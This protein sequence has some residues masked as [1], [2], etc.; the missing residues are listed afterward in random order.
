MS[1][2]TTKKEKFADLKRR[3][4]EQKSRSAVPHTELDSATME[5]IDSVDDP[6]LRLSIMDIRADRTQP[7]QA[8][9]S[10]ISVN[11]NGNPQEV[12]DMLNRWRLI[13]EQRAGITIPVEDI[14]YGRNEKT[15]ELKTAHPYFTGYI[16]L[17]TLAQ[18]IHREG[19]SN[20]VN[21]IRNSGQYPYIIESGER[22]WLAHHILNHYVDAK[23]GRVKAV[24]GDV[25]ES[26]WRQCSENNQRTNLNAIGKARQI[27]KLIMECRAGLTD[28]MSFEDI[29]VGCNRIFFAQV[30]NGNLHKIPDGM[31][32]RVQAALHMTR[33]T[34]SDYRSLLALTEDNEVNDILWMRADD[35]WW[36]QDDLLSFRKIPLNTLREIVLREAFT[37]EDLKKEVG[38]FGIPN[39]PL[40]GSDDM[41]PT[42]PPK[43]QLKKGVIILR[44]L[45]DYWRIEKVDYMNDEFLCVSPSGFGQRIKYSDIADIDNNKA[46]LFKPK[47][48]TTPRKAT[49][50]PSRRADYE[51][52]QRVLI[53]GNRDIKGVVASRK[54]MGGYTINLM[55]G[56]SRWFGES[57]LTPIAEFS[58][59]A[60][61]PRG[62]DTPTIKEERGA[63]DNESDYT[64]PDDDGEWEDEDDKGDPV[65]KTPKPVDMQLVIQKLADIATLLDLPEQPILDDLA[66]LNRERLQAIIQDGGYNHDLLEQLMN[67]YY[68]AVTD[69]VEKIRWW[70]HAYIDTIRAAGFEVLRDANALT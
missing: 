46:D 67:D 27:A 32:G 48:T 21:V 50:T 35:E 24:E 4:D 2:T 29:V 65:S 18:S 51:V 42:P 40:S 41:K 5:A 19:L 23:Y 58:N 59:S 64:T 10:L 68:K 15:F 11:W 49:S 34:M 6:T 9:P 36:T 70:G 43:N 12:L 31:S 22:R 14:L 20:P 47:A 66:K 57:R 7:R 16:E 61:Q 63:S 33:S 38:L 25:K 17:L 56:G 55:K 52:G 37:L 44:R 26:A 39:N 8:M 62:A 30:A 3:L 60:A 28:Y 1:N 13:A 53:D 45:G 54:S 69:A